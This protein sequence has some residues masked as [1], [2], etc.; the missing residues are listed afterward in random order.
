MSRPSADRAQAERLVGADVGDH[1]VVI[2]S[3]P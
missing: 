2:A 1:D 3:H